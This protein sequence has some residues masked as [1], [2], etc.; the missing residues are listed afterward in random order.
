MN[1]SKSLR[2]IYTIKYIMLNIAIAIVYYLVIQ[3][4]LS[5]QQ[6]GILITTVPLY[7][8]YALTVSSSIAFTIA[9]YS[10]S[11]TRKNSA[12]YSASSISA[13]TTVIGGILSGCGC[14]AAILFNVL[15]ISVGT[16]EATLINTIATE[17]SIFIFIAMIIINLFVI[18]YYLDKLS[19]PG[20]KIKY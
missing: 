1:I 17:N 4:L 13:A 11:N 19:K 6:K 16:G 20:C 18:V 10:V 5:I 3:Y 12:K 8:I 15:A 7:L 14:Q 9:I 2:N